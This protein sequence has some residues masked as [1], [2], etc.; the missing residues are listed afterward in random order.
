MANS[1][2]YPGPTNVYLPSL[3]ASGKLIVHYSK[4]PDEFA[5]NRYAGITNVKDW[6]GRYLRMHSADTVRTLSAA[7]DDKVWQDGAQM[8][9]PGVHI[10]HEYHPFNCRRYVESFALGDQ[11][12][13]SADWDII[14]TYAAGAASLI[15]THRSRFALTV[16]DTAGN[17]EGNTATAAALGGDV[18]DTGTA[19][20]PHIKLT[21]MGAFRQI[22]L[23]T[24]GKVRPSDL[25]LIVSPV[26]ASEMAVSQEIHSYVKESPFSGNVL[27]GDG[28]FATWGIPQ[29]LY[30]LGEVVVE[31]TVLNTAHRGSADSFSF[32][33]GA[34]SAVLVCRKDGLS[35]PAGG[36]TFNTLT[37]F[38]QEELGVEV[39]ND[40][41]NRR[42]IGRCVS[43]FD[44]KLTAPDSGLLIT[45]VS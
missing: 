41:N 24:N 21:L 6:V 36:T 26:L 5:L 2:Q 8:P 18:W 28:I 20:D 32:A 16:L 15:M 25:T 10:G 34:T 45:S 29:K 22:A 4:N 30:G 3:E 14:A 40:I 38:F 12:V 19:T 17:W 35:S 42:Q 37:G 23:A 27:Q 33:K 11:T 9:D 13:S 1:W 43:T 44:Y 31:D 39:M 7:S